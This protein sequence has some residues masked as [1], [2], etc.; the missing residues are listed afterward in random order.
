MKA[1]LVIPAYNEADNIVEVVRTI[2]NAGYDYVVVNDGSRDDTLAVC[3]THGINVIDL[4]INLGIG[5]AVQT[6]HKY[7]LTHGL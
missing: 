5:G 2:E 1:L 6:G 7:A 3:H 4:G